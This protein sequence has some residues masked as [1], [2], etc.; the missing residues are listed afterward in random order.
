ML[1]AHQR[2]MASVDAPGACGAGRC[3]VEVCRVWRVALLPDGDRRPGGRDAGDVGVGALHVEAL[4][5]AAPLAPRPPSTAR[6]SAKLI[7]GNWS[8]RAQQHQPELQRWPSS[9]LRVPSGGRLDDVRV[10]TWLKSCMACAACRCTGP[11]R[12][13][14]RA[15]GAQRTAPSQVAARV[16]Q[17]SAAQRGANWSACSRAGA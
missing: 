10:G 12:R 16:M 17:P 3:G 9:M 13:P 1:Q 6:C 14:G 4:E 11:R 5:H 7:S 2:G 15:G 8:V